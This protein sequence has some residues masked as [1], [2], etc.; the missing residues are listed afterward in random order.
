MAPVTQTRRF[1]LT[2]AT[3]TSVGVAA[4]VL[5]VVGFARHHAPLGLDATAYYLL[6]GPL[7]RGHGYSD[8]IVAFSGHYVP[9]ANFPPLYP[10]FLAAVQRVGL[11]TVLD[12][13]VVS[14]VV[15]AATVPLVALIGRRL[16][17]ARVGVV[18]CALAAV[19]PFLLASDGSLM[20]ESIAVPLVTVAVLA[21]LWAADAGSWR[22]WIVVGALFGLAALARAEAP[23]LMVAVVGVALLAC[24]RVSGRARFGAAA[25][26]LA[27]FLVLTAPWVGYVSYEFGVR[28]LWATDGAKTLAG[29]NCPSTYYGSSIGLWDVRCVTE[30]DWPK[31]SEATALQMNRGNARAFARAHVSRVPLVAAVRVVR[32]AGLYAPAQQRDFESIESRNAGWQLFSWWCYVAM[33][34]FAACGLVVLVRRGRDGWVVVGALAAIAVT[35]AVTY[36]NQRWRMAVEPLLLVAAAAGIEALRSRVAP[37]IH[38]R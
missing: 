16:A 23:I 15:G 37:R 35:A 24:S 19:W 20:A 33:L 13:R 32:A 11:R 36:G 5:Y 1:A 29:A 26:A 25:A 38:R 4:R 31:R 21:A 14:S 3:L 18:A 30:A 34:P 12:A 9:T 27:G 22:R 10:L 2:V 17:G 6:A 7:L 28:G 8:G